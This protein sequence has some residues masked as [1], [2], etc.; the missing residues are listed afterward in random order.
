MTLTRQQQQRCPPEDEAIAQG[1]ACLSLYQ[2][3]G[4][5]WVGV[6][7]AHLGCTEVIQLHQQARLSVCVSWEKESVP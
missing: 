1:S 7:A 6:Y 5:V 2:L 3:G 4:V